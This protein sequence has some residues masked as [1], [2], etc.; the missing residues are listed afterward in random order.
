M[1]D[2]LYVVYALS[3]SMLVDTKVLEDERTNEKA[4]ASKGAE[5]L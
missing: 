4:E 5:K 2:M 3:S 1:E